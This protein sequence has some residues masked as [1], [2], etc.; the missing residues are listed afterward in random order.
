MS[1]E[2]AVIDDA[3]V[4]AVFNLLSRMDFSAVDR[5]LVDRI[6]G[7]DYLDGL[8]E[9]TL[10][11]IAISSTL[12]GVYAPSLRVD[13]Y[14]HEMVLNTRLYQDVSERLGT[15]LHHVPSDK[16]EHEA[17]KNTLEAYRAVFGEPKSG[18]WGPA[19]AG[20]CSAACSGG[21]GCTSHCST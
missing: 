12:G 8:R 6:K 16:P 18:Y 1:L 21:S 19:G 2:T 15:F 3:K 7:K 20:E 14:W 10:K 5:K 9:E 4:R 17:Y 13:E 11:F